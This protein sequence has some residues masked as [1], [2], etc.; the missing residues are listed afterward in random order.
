[1][2]S[3]TI[4]Q[5]I[6]DVILIAFEIKFYKQSRDNHNSSQILC[7]PPQWQVITVCG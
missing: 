2:K 5:I 6:F 3:I 1:M 4:L 7:N